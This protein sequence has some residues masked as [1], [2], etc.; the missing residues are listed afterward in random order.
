MDNMEF[1]YK[2]S[3]IV[4]VYNVEKYLRDCLD[5]LLAQTI[6]HE[7]MEVLLIN[8]GSNDDSLAICEE[9]SELF[10][11]F[12]VFDK[13]NGGVSSARNLGIRNAKGKYIFYLDSDDIITPITIKAVTEY[14]DIVYDKVDL[15]TY[16]IQSYENNVKLALHF[17]YL[18]L[19]KTGLYDLSENPYIC[20]TTMNICV[21]N[22]F[23]DNTFF[24]EMKKVH[25]DQEYING[26]L[27]K[28]NVLGFCDK[29]E[30]M[31]IKNGSSAMSKHAFAMYCFEP[32]M[33]YYEELFAKYENVPLY[34]QGMFIHDFNWKLRDNRLFPY[35]YDKEQFENAM[36]RISLLIS[37]I[38]IEV[39]LNH[40]SIDEFHKYYY[41]SLRKEPVIPITSH[42][43]C[44]LL[45]R[46]KIVLTEK[47]IEII[48]RRIKVFDGVVKIYGSIKSP[49]FSFLPQPKLF[50]LINDKET[51]ENT[52]SVSGSSWYRSK[53][54]TNNFWAFIFEYDITKISKLRFQI[55]IDGL[56]LDA[57]YWFSNASPFNSATNMSKYIINDYLIEYK[58]KTFF[59]SY[60]NNNVKKEIY[61]L[62]NAKLEDSVIS[63]RANCIKFKSNFKKDVWLYYDNYTV[64]YDNG[65]LQFIHDF[66]KDDKIDR[67]Y[68]YDCDF[69]KKEH[70]FEKKHLSHLIRFGSLRHK[71][72]YLASSKIFS[73]FMEHFSLTPFVTKEEEK[74]V[75]L[76]NA[77]IIYLQHG[78]LHANIPWYY[79]PEMVEIDKIVVSSYFEIKNMV[80]KYGFQKK[81]LIPTG[82][83]RFDMINKTK[84]P[85]NK[86]IFAPSWREYLIGKYTDF[87]SRRNNE[88]DKLLNSNYFQNIMSFVNNHR[89]LKILQEKDLYLDLKLH[90][91]FYET[92]SHLVEIESERISLAPNKVDLTEYQMFITDFSSFVFDFAYLSRPIMYFVPDYLEF[93]SGM[94]HYRELDLPWE[95][96]FGN[97]AI[98]AE[99]AVDEVIRIINNNFVPDPVFKERMD[100]FFLPL[101]NCAEKLYDYLMNID[102]QLLQ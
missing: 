78:V 45:C 65:Y 3:V 52:L 68:I 63:L 44:Q 40:P 81:D 32:T 83:P 71:I 86:I 99:K 98:D 1:E 80:Q 96:A 27:N 41:L 46:N 34:Y 85:K 51:V 84:K 70:L 36:A 26:I 16:K 23:E 42:N 29:G 95:K 28:K 89:L 25:E 48:I 54:K 88:D 75:D 43:N 19:Q 77:E 82:M 90:P 9:Y 92:Y 69:K 87:V 14:F 74:Y 15:V 50:A 94:N 66:E 58:E 6:D 39:I 91:N 100:S 7:L 49:V 2:V 97:L 56:K 102:K 76:F 24:N 37:K 101:E 93:K 61:S 11:C 33:E 4:P 5:S 38:D 60:A 21:K 20:Q 67:Y 13:E 30:Y 12:K 17:R 79:T 73:S 53:T 31:Y 57:R 72:L 59:F 35:H 8:D 64:E 55:E 22:F 10:S 47:T 62:N 18:V